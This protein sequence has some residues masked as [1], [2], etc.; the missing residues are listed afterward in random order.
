MDDTRSDDVGAVCVLH[1]DPPLPRWLH[2]LAEAVPL[3]LV[4]NDPAP[5]RY[6]GLPAAATTLVNDEP[7]GFAA[8][9]DAAVET[10]VRTA[11][12][13]TVLV[14]NFDLDLEPPALDSLVTALRADPGLAAVGPLLVDADGRPVFSAGRLPR[15]PVEFLRA[16]GLRQGVW[17]RL[18]RAV[19]R[20]T[21]SW[22]HRNAVTS[23]APVRV[24]EPGEYLPWTCVA[25]RLAAWADVGPL[26]PRFRLYA[27]DIDWSVRATA[28]GRR[29]AL[30]RTEPPVVHGERWTRSPTTDAWFEASHARLHA[31]YGWTAN[32]R[33]QR[34]GLALRRW[35]PLRWTGRLTWSEVSA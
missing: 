3:V 11:R 23:T 2:D 13:D 26:D 21:R 20:R 5:G 8:N 28:S 4:V 33:A 17:L 34:L 15:P 27:E 14:L 18:Q 1:G 16:A 31:K 29:L 25:V 19:M 32:A 6:T 9:V 24:L 35:T 22:S 30:V 10:L 7:A 12:I